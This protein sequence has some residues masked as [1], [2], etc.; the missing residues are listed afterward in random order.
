MSGTTVQPKR[1]YWL[2][3]LTVIAA[4]AGALVMRQVAVAALGLETPPLQ[5]TAQA[6]TFFTVVLSTFAVLVFVWT[7]RMAKDPIRTYLR[8]SLVALVLSFI[9]D[10]ALAMTH[11]PGVTWAVAVALMLE[12]VG[13]AAIVLGL[14]TRFSRA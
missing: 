10:A 1:L 11:Q 13:V 9:P 14:L 6:T 8:I 5:L 3:P 2:G 4:L 12:H 7:A